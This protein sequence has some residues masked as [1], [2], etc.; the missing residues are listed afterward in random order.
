MR[1]DR[2]LSIVLLLRNRGRMSASA[3]ARE[4]EVSTRTVLRDIDALSTAGIPVF[5]ERGRDGGF[6]LLPGFTTDLTG[7]TAAEAKALL[8]A[9]SAGTSQSLGMAPEF[10]SAMRKVAAAMPDAHRVAATKVAQRVLVRPDGWLKDPPQ[11][12]RYLGAIQQ[13]VFVGR[14][15][16]ILYGSRGAESRWRTVDPIGLINAGGVWY[17]IATDGGSER[18][19]R[20][21]R[22]GDVV[23]LDEP[24]QRSAEVDLA[25]IWDR[26]RAAFRAGLGETITAV[27]LVR[28]KHREML[29]GTVIAVRSEEVTPDGW[30]RMEV[31]FGDIGHVGAVL[32]RLG[33][34]AEL[35]GPDE[36]RTSVRELALR[37]AER[38]G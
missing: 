38:H 24:A 11:V 12:E 14:R 25:Q 5:A 27:V 31:E 2:L 18:T 10:A 33:E 13:A 7:L 21:N 19:Y 20:L 36:L 8:V 29:S 23:E 32:W 28:Q 35:I 34:D 15:L 9:G 3:L 30:L 16:K 6:E 26:R 37:M 1:A 22:L 4:L 17:L